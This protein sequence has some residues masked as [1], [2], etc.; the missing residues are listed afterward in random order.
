MTT[1]PTVHQSLSVESAAG[2]SKC[3]QPLTGRPA[4]VAGAVS[5]VTPDVARRPLDFH[6][7]QV[8]L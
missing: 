3:Q 7:N 4:A 5:S 1:G 8:K 2:T 6:G